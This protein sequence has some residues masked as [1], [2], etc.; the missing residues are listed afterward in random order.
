MAMD[1]KESMS[2][3]KQIAAKS[4]ILSAGLMLVLLFLSFPSFGFSLNSRTSSN[5]KGWAN[6][7]VKFQI[8]TANCPAGVDVTGIINQALDLWNN[9]ATSN[10]KVSVVGTTTSTSPSDP[11][12]I[13]CDTNYDLPDSSPGAAVVQPSTGD[14]ITSG[15]MYLNATSGRA[16]IANFSEAIV[17]VT[18]AHEIGH[19]LG[20]GHSQ[21][22]N[23]LM[24]YDASLKTTLGLAQDDIDGITYLYPRNEFGKDKP[25]GCGLVVNDQPPTT[26]T[27]IAFLS[28]F[29]LPLS[30]A[31]ACKR[32]T[33]KIGFQTYP[34]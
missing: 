21:D 7:D 29:M 25:M 12:T 5:F 26:G 1:F 32:V 28:L 33:R 10:L 17:A 18:L 27:M 34:A 20:L 11:I 19:L 22:L 16:N 6:P 13:M 2:I 24:Y 31:L 9:I 8:N 15:I 4:S 3:Q 30:A 23:A 14:F